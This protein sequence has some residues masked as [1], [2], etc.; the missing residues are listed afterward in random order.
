MKN[1]ITVNDIYSV[2]TKLKLWFHMSDQYREVGFYDGIDEMIALFDNGEA[3]Y[4]LIIK[5]VMTEPHQLYKQMEEEDYK[6]LPRDYHGDMEDWL[7]ECSE[8]DD[9]YFCI[10]VCIVAYELYDTAA[11]DLVHTLRELMETENERA[12]YRAVISAMTDL[13]IDIDALLTTR[14]AVC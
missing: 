13:R 3:A 9:L 4:D 10:A 7:N 5:R 8:I 1:N 14:K 12:R 2:F 11:V 6:T